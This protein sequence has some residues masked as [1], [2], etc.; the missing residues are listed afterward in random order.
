MKTE[1]KLSD[2]VKSIDEELNSGEAM[3]IVYRVLLSIKEQTIAAVEKYGYTY[4]IDGNT[5]IIL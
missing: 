2:W 3:P 4:D 5:K 1:I